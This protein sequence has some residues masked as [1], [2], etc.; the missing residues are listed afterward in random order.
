V[1]DVSGSS[2]KSAYEVRVAPVPKGS[3]A[4]WTR[5]MGGEGRIQLRS[6]GRNGALGA[7][8]TIS[9]TGVD[10]CFP[11]LSVAPDG[12]AM[13]GWWVDGSNPRV[14]GRRIRKDGSL[15]PILAVSG[16]GADRFDVALGLDGAATF[17]WVYSQR[18][19]SIK[20][21][22][23]EAD[24]SMGPVQDLSGER[25]DAWSPAIAIG[26]DGVATAVW[27]R[28]ADDGKDDLVESRRIDSDG[29]LGP[30][31]RLGTGNLSIEPP[32]VEVALDGAVTVVWTT[33]G[34]ALRARRITPDG[35]L[36]PIGLLSDGTR[37]RLGPNLALAPSG[38][39]T[40][41]W[42]RAAAGG[43]VVE[44]RRIGPT[45]GLG[46][47]RVLARNAG[48]GA[49]PDVAV[50]SRGGAVVVWPNGV[51]TVVSRRLRAD[52]SL[53]T[54]R[55]FNARGRVDEPQVALRPDGTTAVLW[56]SQRPSLAY[57]ARYVIEGSVQQAATS[58]LRSP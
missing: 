37:S 43:F 44:A 39:A 40:V 24:G 31:R 3:I 25:L 58:L 53:S 9:A 7:V 42:G 19:Y 33:S 56:T 26:S 29:T 15:G 14:E 8:R 20:A 1:L 17:V 50:G 35:T 11:K 52:G 21:R 34:R 22:R 5:W 51:H 30:V 49:W 4:V 55:K 45:G 48:G 57:G 41:V 46:R 13:V 18:M 2:P 54:T 28:L 36:G 12:S 27:Q 16:A 32:Q 10:A 23:V 6:I 38:V 47:V